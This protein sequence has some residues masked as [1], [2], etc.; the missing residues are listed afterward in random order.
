VRVAAGLFFEYHNLL[1][2]VCGEIA[3]AAR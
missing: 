3:D 2:P 1:G